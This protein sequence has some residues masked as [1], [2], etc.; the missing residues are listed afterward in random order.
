MTRLRVLC[1]A[2]AGT[3]F[4]A[5]AAL[6]PAEAQQRGRVTYG[7]S[8]GYQTLQGDPESGYGFYAL[9]GGAKGA[10]A[11]VGRY[12]VSP[13]LPPNPP[14]ASPPATYRNNAVRYAETAGAVDDATFLPPGPQGGARQGVFDANDGAGTPFFGGYYSAGGGNMSAPGAGSPDLPFDGW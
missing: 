1:W 11:T 10:L 14:P 3:A 2:L 12:G 4:G 7:P 9:P 8:A 13:G 5:L 6:P